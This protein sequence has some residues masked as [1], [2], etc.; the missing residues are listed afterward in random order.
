[1][2]RLKAIITV[3]MM[4]VH[5]DQAKS[6]QLSTTSYFPIVCSLLMIDLASMKKR[7]RKKFD[8]YYVMTK[9]NVAFRIT[10]IMFQFTK[11]LCLTKYDK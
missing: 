4:H 11:M 5:P 1:M 8:I 7:M 2:P 9:E 6:K 10:P 3:S